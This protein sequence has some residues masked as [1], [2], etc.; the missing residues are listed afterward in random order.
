MRPSLFIFKSH[1]RIPHWTL[2]LLAALFLFPAGARAATFDPG[3]K[4]R[5]IETPHF[6]VHYHEELSPLAQ[7]AAQYCELAYDIVT[8]RFQWRPAGKTQVVLLDTTDYANGFAFLLPYNYIRLFVTVPESSSPLD[9]YDDWLQNLILHEY[10]H[11]VMLDM[12]EGLPLFLQRIFGHVVLPNSVHPHWILEGV[13]TW[14]ET[15]ESPGGRGRS[16]FVDMILRMDALSGRFLSIDQAVIYFTDW[17]GGNAAYYYGAK[18]HQYLAARHGDHKIREY[19]KRVASFPLPYFT[20][21]LSWRTFGAVF[22]SEWSQW[23]EEITREARA[24]RDIIEKQGI[25]E[26]KRLTFHGGGVGGA[27]YSPSGKRIAYSRSSPRTGPEV[28]LME[29]DGSGDRQLFPDTFSNQI[30]WSRDGESVIFS[31]AAINDRFYTFN[32]VYRYDLFSGK[33][34][35]LSANQLPGGMRQRG[36]SLRARDPD[37]HPGG[38]HVLFVTNRYGQNALVEADV[39]GELRR[40]SSAS[41]RVVKNFQGLDAYSEPRYSPD[42]ETI[43]VSVVRNGQRDIVLMDRQGRELACVTNDGA[44]DTSPVWSPDG[45]LIFYASD[46][47]GVWNIHAWERST[48][49]RWQVTNVV[50]GA[51]TPDASPDGKSLLYRNYLPDGY[52]IFELPLDREQWIPVPDLI[53]SGDPPPSRFARMSEGKADFPVHDYNPWDTLKPSV[54]NWVLIPTLLLR[55]N[56]VELGL[57]TFGSD[58]LQYHGYTLQGTFSAF[59]RE[60]GASVTYEFNRLYPTFVFNLSTF[61]IQFPQRLAV[62]DG[63]M[64]PVRLAG[65][66]LYVERRNRASAAMHTP[67]FQRHLLITGYSFERRD[68]AADVPD[69]AITGIIP[70]GGDH[71]RVTLGYRYSWTRSFSRSISLENGRSVGLA[72]DIYSPWLGGDYEE[73]VV[74]TDFRE[75]ITMPWFYNH[76]LAMRVA[77][78]LAFGPNPVQLFRAG[79][80]VGESLIS[81]ATENFFPIRGFPTSFLT[82]RGAAM[83][84][85]EY[86]LPLLYVDHGLFT[87]PFFIQNLSLAVFADGGTAYAGEDRPESI[88]DNLSLGTGLEL[89]SSMSLT[90]G[91]PLVIRGGVA[92]GLTQQGVRSF[93]GMLYFLIGQSF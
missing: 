82:G 37:I 2:P 68:S 73:A 77:G 69:N 91:P 85:L 79:G 32:D 93:P 33:A 65:D 16:P 74:T 17:P 44:R 24:Q 3:L 67:L 83:A 6:S 52:D 29:R 40:W 25:R 50:G 46:R 18:F 8:A 78:G 56:D 90:F 45:G 41:L 61:I 38:R 72:L 70:A 14:V 28:R 53:P 12:T 36:S 48:G 86:R 66:G 11:I 51:F 87:L 19:Y 62:R 60:F 42:G 59:T 43:A 57:L 47:T 55:E 22:E 92:A 9:V 84:S 13:A 10:A 81:A 49:R 54:N 76:V 58:I 71:A 7:M 23:R 27:R 5:T 21:L 31:Q 80:A 88:R 15:V 35:M 75:Y 20:L 64:D 1:A 26:G 30:A 34:Y 39:E 4:W 63:P 89:R